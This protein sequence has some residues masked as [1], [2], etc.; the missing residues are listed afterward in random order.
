MLFIEQSNSH[1][2]TIKFMAE[3]LGRETM[4]LAINV[5]KGQSFLDLWVKM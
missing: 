1:H 2:P 3:V 4:F 5:Y